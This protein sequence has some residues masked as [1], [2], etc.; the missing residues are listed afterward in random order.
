MT[1]YELLDLI[2]SGTD[3]MADMFSLYLTVLS[4][5]LL[6]GYIAGS[7]LTGLQ[8]GGLTSLFLFA[9]TGQALGIYQNGVHIGDLYQKK[10]QL[11]ALTAY[12]SQYVANTNVWVVAMIV[13]IALSVFFIWQVRSAEV[14]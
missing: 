10:Q 4:A 1:E 6:V 11:A 9:S 2:A 3:Q 5:Y 13:A 12:E 14:E 8:F 7:K